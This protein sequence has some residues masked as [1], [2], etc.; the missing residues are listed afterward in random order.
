MRLRTPAGSS[1]GDLVHVGANQDAQQIFVHPR[2]PGSAEI[3]VTAT[4]QAPSGVTIPA[5]TVPN[6][7][8][9]MFKVEVKD[10]PL[11]VPGAPTNVNATAGDGQVT[12]TWGEPATGGSA[13]GGFEYTYGIGAAREPWMPHTSPVNERLVTGLT[14]GTEYTFDVRAVNATGA[15][16]SASDT[17][18][19]MATPVD[20]VVPGAPTEVAATAGDG[21]VTLTWTAPT[22]NG[23]VAI[24]TYDYRS[25]VNERMSD[26]TSTG[27]ADTS[28]TVSADNGTAI[29]YDVRAVNSVGAGHATRSN[30]VTPTAALTAP[31][32]PQNLT[33]AAGDGQVMLSWD[34]PTTGGAVSGYEY[35]VTGSGVSGEWMDT[36]STSTAVTGL[37]NGT[38]Y[39]SEVRAVNSAGRSD[40]GEREGDADGSGS[41]CPGH[42]QG[43]EGGYERDRERRP[44]S[45]GRRDGAGWHEGSRRQGG[46]HRVEAGHG[47]VPDR[48]CVDQGRRGR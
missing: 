19:P 11:S 29:A 8:E 31:G 46:A 35:R 34:A 7:A 9:V 45:D 3:T 38:E 28:L 1:R 4:A 41:G 47:L 23:G 14:N 42:G 10:A 39:T 33:A 36:S 5:Q 27:N 48:R 15:G 24:Q 6:V 43:G 30:G 16:P 17:A 22:D 37:T 21:T 40:A 25:I 12:L 2:K 20:P 13:D 44:G 26:W 32:T 18:T